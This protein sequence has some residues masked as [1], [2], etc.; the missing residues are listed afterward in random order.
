MFTKTNDAFEK[1]RLSRVF[2]LIKQQSGCNYSI[3]VHSNHVTRY[4]NAVLVVDGNGSKLTHDCN[5]Q[6]SLVICTENIG[7]HRTNITRPI[8]LKIRP[9]K[10]PKFQFKIYPVSNSGL[11]N[12]MFVKL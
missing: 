7:S 9:S 8:T 10:K 4:N 5:I 6:L 1:C 2:F 12:S 3:I 11:T